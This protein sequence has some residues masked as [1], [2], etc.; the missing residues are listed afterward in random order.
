MFYVKLW[1]ND[2]IF[3]FLLT[4]KNADLIEMIQMMISSIILQHIV[5]RMSLKKLPF[6]ILIWEWMIYFSCLQAIQILLKNNRDWICRENFLSTT[7]MHSILIEK[8]SNIS[9][10]N[11]EKYKTDNFR[12][13]HIIYIYDIYSSFRFGI[14]Q[15][16]LSIFPLLAKDAFQHLLHF[17]SGKVS[18][19]G[20][21]I[22][23]FDETLTLSFS[24][25]DCQNLFILWN[26]IKIIWI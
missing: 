24:Y 9:L 2:K 8:H 13:L 17:A 10:W 14:L 25:N 4:C 22:Q 20:G 5:L 12:L 26:W 7:R 18:G 11:G 19:L 6:K 23:R 1:V 21:I 3:Q 16:S 15:K